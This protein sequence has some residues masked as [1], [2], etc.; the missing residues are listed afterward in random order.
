M[1]LGSAESDLEV[2]YTALRWATT[3]RVGKG[4]RLLNFHPLQGVSHPHEPNPKR[5]VATWERFHKVRSAAQELAAK[6]ETA[7]DA[8]TDNTTRPVVEAERTK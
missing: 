5:P 1:R 7:R 6:E 2:P 8:T 4:K 3:F